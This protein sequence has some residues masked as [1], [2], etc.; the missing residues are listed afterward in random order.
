MPFSAHL[1]RLRLLLV[2][3][4]FLASLFSARM[5]SSHRQECTAPRP[6]FVL[7]RQPADSPRRFRSHSGHFTTTGSKLVKRV[8]RESRYKPAD[9]N[10]VAASADE[11]HAREAVPSR[12]SSESRLERMLQTITPEA[13]DAGWYDLHV[14]PGGL[15]VQPYAREIPSFSSYSRSAQDWSVRFCPLVGLLVDKLIARTACGRHFCSQP[16][17]RGPS[18]SRPASR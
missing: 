16:R 10:L 15:E 1:P 17:S 2:L 11:V 18:R 13:Y 3:E 8:H 9:G 5:F 6:S 14:L 4:L 7:A 12:A